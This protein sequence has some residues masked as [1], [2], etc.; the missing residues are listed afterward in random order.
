MSKKNRQRREVAPPTPYEQARD[1]L[2]Q[3]IMRCDVI[4]AA[5]EHQVEWF[6]ETMAYFADRYP[7][8]KPA[9]IKELRVLG[10]RFVQPPKRSTETIPETPAQ[11]PAASEATETVTTDEVGTDTIEGAETATADVEADVETEAEAEEP[12]GV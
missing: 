1:E 11:A 6:T 3:Q 8:L 4:G 5:P 9:D 10:E 12:V 7:E 2:F